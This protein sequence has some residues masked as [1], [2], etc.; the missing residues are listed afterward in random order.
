LITAARNLQNGIEPPGLSEAVPWDK[1]RSEEII[2]GP[3]DDP[4]EVAN[5]AGESAAR[6]EKL[7][8]PVA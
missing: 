2:I 1:I 4:W 5:E 8:V 7:I 3:D 6:G